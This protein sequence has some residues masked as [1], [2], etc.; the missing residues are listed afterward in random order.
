[1]SDWII[2]TIN[3]AFSFVAIFIIA[4]MLGKK[5]VAQLTV[6]DYVVGISIG[7]I[8]G[9]WATD[10]KNPWYYYLV[11]MGIFFLLTIFIDLLERK[12]P[13]KKLLKGKQL[14]LLT[15]GKINYKNLKKS[16]LDI[17]DL[18]GLCRAKNYFDLDQISYIF[19][20][21]NGEISILPKP[22]YRP[23]THR[24]IH[25]HTTAVSQPTKYLII[26]G[27]INYTVLAS[28]SRDKQWLYEACHLHT[29]RDLK[30]IILA[31]Y[32]S[33]KKI[34]LHKKDESTHSRPHQNIQS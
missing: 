21:N 26:D 17:N 18:L 20:E 16:K 3:S 9:Q 7:N 30:N 19:F 23:L 2:I 28:I 34:I 14:E 1:M 11:A 15:D 31:E 24:D 12:I 25:A 13:F 29:R 6:V 8:A 32:I 4:N 33:P 22:D 10:F 5:Q 27:H